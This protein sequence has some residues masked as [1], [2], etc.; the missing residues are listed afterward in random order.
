[1]SVT[2]QGRTVIMASRKR[3]WASEAHC[4][5]VS[6]SR[7]LFGLAI[8]LNKFVKLLYHPTGRHKHHQQITMLRINIDL[9][10][11]MGTISN[12]QCRVAGRRLVG[13]SGIKTFLAYR[14]GPMFSV[15]WMIA[16]FLLGGASGM[17]VFAMITVAAD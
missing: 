15:W 13:H 10:K 8:L 14:R 12:E 9:K 17:L 11:T 16:V 3:S 7:C 2:R 4:R 6:G 5:D 1:M